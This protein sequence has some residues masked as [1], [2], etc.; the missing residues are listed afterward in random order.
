MILKILYSEIGVKMF[1]GT[2]ILEPIVVSN[3]QLS[4]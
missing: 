3:I 2:N 1:L 4:N